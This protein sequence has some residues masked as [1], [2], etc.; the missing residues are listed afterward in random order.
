MSNPF[1]MITHSYSG[2][3]KMWITEYLSIQKQNETN[4]SKNVYTYVSYNQQ[5]RPISHIIHGID[6]L[7]KSNMLQGC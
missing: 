5:I 6:T 7:S 1:Q 4:M 2:Y 3:H